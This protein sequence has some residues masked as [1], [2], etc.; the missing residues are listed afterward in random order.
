ML[1]DTALSAY[2][3]PPNGCSNREDNAKYSLLQYRFFIHFVLFLLFTRWQKILHV[4]IQVQLIN[5]NT[6]TFVLANKCFTIHNQ[7]HYL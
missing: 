1:M 7:I 4:C 3:S 6:E 5:S 2:K